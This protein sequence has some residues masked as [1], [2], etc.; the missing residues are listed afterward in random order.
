MKLLTFIKELILNKSFW[1][2]FIICTAF[3]SKYIFGDD[4]LLEEFGEKTAK[5]VLDIDV[6]FSPDTVDLDFHK[7]LR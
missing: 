3:F 4:N 6:D 2:G 5:E 1:I 7:E